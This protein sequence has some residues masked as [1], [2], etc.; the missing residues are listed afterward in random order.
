MVVVVIVAATACETERR[1][2]DDDE[3]SVAKDNLL[4]TVGSASF[5]SPSTTWRT[6]ER[7]SI[8]E[9]A[10]HNIALVRNARVGY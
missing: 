3:P 5:G 9:N 4:Q 10:P 2:E 1:I 8:L 7:T 6:R